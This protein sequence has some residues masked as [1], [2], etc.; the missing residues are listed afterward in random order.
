[1][2]LAAL[3]IV[4]YGVR[5]AA[6]SL[7][8]EPELLGDERYYVDVAT[9]IAA[10]EGHVSKRF[11][12]VAGWPPGYPFALSLSISEG[13]ATQA[14]E[15][16]LRSA[17]HRAQLLLSTALVLAVAILGAQMF[18]VRTGLA[19]GFVAALYP[20][21][22]AFGH[23]FW[24]GTFFT[25]LVAI[26]WL[27]ALEARRRDAW[28]LAALCGV[29]FGL[30]GLT[31]EVGLLL[32]GAA[33]LWWAHLRV[34]EIRDRGIGNDLRARIR[35]C[36][37]PALVATLAVAVVLPWTWRNARELDRLVPVSIVGWMA[38]REGNT[39]PRG[40]GWMQLDS[41][42]LD[43]FRAAYFALE[44]DAARL[45]MA[46]GQALGL[47][48]REQPTWLL[49]KL[50][51]N[52]NLLFAPDSFLFKKMSH[53][54]YGELAP[55]PRRA[56]VAS[57]LASYLA[58]L[59]AAIAGLA[60]DPRRD[61]QAFALLAIGVV[62]AL[63][64]LANASSRYRLPLLP[65]LAV[66]AASTLLH[67]AEVWGRLRGPRLAAAALALAFVAAVCIPHS[68]EDVASLWTRGTYLEP[69]RD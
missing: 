33:A 7:A 23:Y 34:R 35:A 13:A 65:L 60:A 2:G 27:L 53:G 3:A 15:R 29:L 8:G 48:A 49:K 43:A 45:D 6:L 42:S 19:A 44:D 46:R 20:S 47:I 11:G 1:M 25:L 21:L 16:S 54:S 31:R 5:W 57:T 56:L 36:A 32:A 41:A 10:G 58:L 55:L 4:G 26:A 18:D 9:R 38:L 28:W 69:L 39:L 17:L 51:R 12:M 67:P 68:W 59:A 37:K 30:A 66:Y 64:V 22:V 14:D 50:A 24:S 61:R 62:V 52:L 63:H 40:D